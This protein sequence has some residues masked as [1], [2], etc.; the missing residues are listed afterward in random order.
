M[1][2]ETIYQTDYHNKLVY[3]EIIKVDIMGIENV[4][5]HIDNLVDNHTLEYK[6]DGIEF[7]KKKYEVCIM[8][9]DYVMMRK[10]IVIIYDVKTKNK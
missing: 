8:D 10:T 2:K 4:E 9:D 3:T 5:T 7:T 6:V 1:K